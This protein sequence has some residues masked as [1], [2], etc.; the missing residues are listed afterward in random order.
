MKQYIKIFL[1]V[2]L[3]ILLGSLTFIFAQTTKRADGQ[4][5]GGDKRSFRPLPPGMMGGGLPPQ[6]LEKLNLSDQQKEQIKTLEENSR[7]ASK[8]YFDKL[9][10]LDDQLRTVTD[11]ETFDEEQS[12]AILANK[13][14]VMAELELI[15]LKTG[16]A[17][18][19]ILT[20]EQ[21]TQLEQLKQ[22]RPEMPRG[23]FR[24][25]IPPPVEN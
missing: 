24:P 9:K 21:K 4:F 1:P 25:D 22:Q 15:R 3:V 20:A 13:A 12:R 14:Q 19:N 10:S 6:V 17:V 18:K 5:P 23:G 8:T 7:T 11:G 2:S 16:I